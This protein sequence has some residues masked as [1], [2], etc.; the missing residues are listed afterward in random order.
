MTS[1]RRDASTS[2]IFFPFSH[3]CP[4]CWVNSGESHFAGLRSSCADDAGVFGEFD[5]GF[6]RMQEVEGVDAVDYFD[7]MPLVRQ[8]V[9]ETIEVHGVTAEAVG[10]VKRRE[11]EKVQRACHWSGTL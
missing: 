6:F 11:V 7:V 10:R 3:G 5:L 4:V 2:R 9:A 8:P 1:K